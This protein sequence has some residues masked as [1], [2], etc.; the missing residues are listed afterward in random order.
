MYKTDKLR[1]QH[2]ESVWRKEELTLSIFLF[3]RESIKQIQSLIPNQYFPQEFD[4]VH[5]LIEN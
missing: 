2:A 5:D 4:S 3:T 1:A